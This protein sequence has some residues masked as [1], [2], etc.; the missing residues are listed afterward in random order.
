M[1]NILVHLSKCLFL[2]I[3]GFVVACNGS[4][5]VPQEHHHA[6]QT[7]TYIEGDLQCGLLDKTGILWFGTNNGIYRYDGTSFTYLSEKDGL[8]NPIVTAILEDTAGNLWFG[9]AEGLCLYD[10]YT[11]THVPIPFS[12]TSSTWLDKVYP[13]VNPNQV[14]ALLQDS[15]GYIWIGTNGAGAY[16]YDGQT[17]TQYL[18]DVGKVYE[19][20]LQHNIIL[21]I[22]EDQSENIWFTSLSHAG[23][24][25]YDGEAF[26]HFMTE[27]GLSD[28]FVRTSYVDH[29]GDV[30]IGTHGNRNGGLDRFD[31]QS[32]TNFR[33]TDDG[34][35]HNNILCISEDPLGNL[36]LGSNVTNLCLF[37][38]ETFREFRSKEGK[39]FGNI[40]AIV[41]DSAGNMWFGGRNSLWRYDGQNVSSFG[42]QH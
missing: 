39:S 26:R 24:S 21:S 31:G 36:W 16:R 6:H 32:F 30:W 5:E 14:M 1:N 4:K 13:I 19:D 20:G 22:T 41:R 15:E 40:L 33:K 23:V 42:S 25:R 3:L 11:F 7:S 12:D 10:G 18:S 2:I 38:G 8:C 34:F 35:F 28:N 27:D 37:D 29:L 17:F 9:T